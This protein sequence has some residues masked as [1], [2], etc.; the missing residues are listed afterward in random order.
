MRGAAA[1][2]IGALVVPLGY[3]LAATAATADSLRSAAMG[4]PVPLRRMRPP[5]QVPLDRP[6][7]RYD[8]SEVCPV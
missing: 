1:G 7:P 6:L 3:V 2:A 5:R 4:M 8:W